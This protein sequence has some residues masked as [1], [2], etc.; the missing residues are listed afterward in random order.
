MS[1]P[2]T[3]S[4]RKPQRT[5]IG[6]GGR[7]NQDELFRIKRSADGVIHIGA[8]GNISGRSAYVCKNISCV[9][10]ARK[11]RGLERSYKASVPKEIY[12]AL[13]EEFRSDEK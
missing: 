7:F 12:D 4:D 2:M 11:K 6:C 10:K 8:Y 5:C 9:E 3:K 13:E 1:R